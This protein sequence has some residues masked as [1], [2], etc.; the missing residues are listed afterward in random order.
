MATT[1][2]AATMTVTVQEEITLKGYEQGAKN[3]L[4]IGSIAKDR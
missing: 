3:T 1:I 4:T 2:E